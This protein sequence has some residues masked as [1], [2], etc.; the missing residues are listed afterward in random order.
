MKKVL[1]FLM[2]FFSSAMFSIAQELEKT[3]IMT[4]HGTS[5]EFMALFGGLNVFRII[6]FV[7]MGIIGL[8]SFV[9]NKKTIWGFAS[10]HLV[11]LLF[12][13]LLSTSIYPSDPKNIEDMA[14]FMLVFGILI[15]FISGSFLVLTK[16]KK[17]MK[18]TEKKEKE[19]GDQSAQ[20]EGVIL[21]VTPERNVLS[22]V[23][24]AF[25]ISLF[26]ISLLQLTIPFFDPIINALFGFFGAL[27]VLFS[28]VFAFLIVGKN[29]Y[30][31]SEQRESIS[32]KI[33][34]LM[35][36]FLAFQWCVYMLMDLGRLFW[37][38]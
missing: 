26:V 17:V 34:I 2:M 13:M 8:L 24:T 3:E 30:K 36:I 9:T 25:G 19:K 10:W 18:K 21:V 15:V 31:D 12:L 4:A 20:Q 28:F 32:R 33:L 14:L 35:T 27:I 37:S 23:L 5:A 38:H 16:L 7:G 22:S 11:V 1:S 6:L 29:P